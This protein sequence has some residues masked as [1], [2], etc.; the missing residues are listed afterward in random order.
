[1][2]RTAAWAWYVKGTSAQYRLGPQVSPAFTATESVEANAKAPRWR[3]PNTTDL[4]LVSGVGY[5]PYRNVSYF[6]SPS[7]LDLDVVAPCIPDQAL[8]DLY[9]DG[10]SMDF[11]MYATVW[12]QKDLRLAI[13]TG[14]EIRLDA[15]TPGS[16]FG[17]DRFINDCG[18]DNPNFAW[19][20]RPQVGMVVGLRHAPDPRPLRRRL[21]LDQPWGAERPDGST[22]LTRAQYGLRG[23][24]LVGP[25][26]NG[27]E[28]TLSAEAWMAWSLRSKASALASFTPYHP[29]FVLGPYLRYQRGALL[30][31]VTDAAGEDSDRYYDLDKS[32]TVLIGLRGQYRL[33]AGSKEPE[34]PTELP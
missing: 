9:S 31:G 13:E 8:P 29:N 34:V 30:S 23:G 5:F 25:G 17:C 15:V 28:Y 1:M 32:H 7:V 3:R 4:N 18:P 11:A 33:K 6:C 16:T 10:I 20:L 2:I 12:F 26:Y 24:F 22:D 21:A 27:M 19:A 14:P